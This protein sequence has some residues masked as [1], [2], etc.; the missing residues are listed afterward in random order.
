MEEEVLEQETVMQESGSENV[1]EDTES[2]S[3]NVQ[4]EPKLSVRTRGQ[5]VKFEEAVGQE[6]EVGKTYNLHFGGNCEVMISESKP[7]SGIITNEVVYTKDETK[8]L[9]VKTGI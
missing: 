5:W 8:H 1:Q 9:W 6:L 3:E 4:P 7:A 2:R